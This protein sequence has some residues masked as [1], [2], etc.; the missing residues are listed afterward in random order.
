M[1]TTSAYIALLDA[2]QP[3][4]SGYQINFM[5]NWISL[6]SVVGWVNKPAPPFTVPPPFNMLVFPSVKLGT[7]KLWWFKILKNSARNC[8]LKLSEIL[9]MLL[10]LNTEK[11]RFVKP[12]PTSVLRPTL[13]RRL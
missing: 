3:K 11:S 10:F 4:M 12:G 13:P 7:L 1:A 2:A 9:L 5:A 8:T 6:E